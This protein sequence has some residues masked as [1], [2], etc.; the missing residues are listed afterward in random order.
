MTDNVEAPANDMADT[1]PLIEH[2]PGA[3]VHQLALKIL[4][5]LREIS[6][7]L[8]LPQLEGLT[9][10]GAISLAVRAHEHVTGTV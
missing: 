8:V 3:G 4:T 10:I 1:D 6:Q 7:G 5:E 9:L 2:R